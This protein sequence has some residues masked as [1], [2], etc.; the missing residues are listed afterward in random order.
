M[1]PECHR[2]T[3]WREAVT[4]REAVQA[5]GKPPEFYL[6]AYRRLLAA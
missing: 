2:L 3:A 6:E 5:I 1:P 4:A